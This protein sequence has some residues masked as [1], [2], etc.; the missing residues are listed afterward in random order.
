MLFN[1]EKHPSFFILLCNFCNGEAA[2]STH[3]T[4]K[5]IITDYY[6]ASGMR[7]FLQNF[8]HADMRGFV[9]NQIELEAIT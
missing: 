1:H 7:Q 4:A 8:K 3:Q 9:V 2:F 5:V 6:L